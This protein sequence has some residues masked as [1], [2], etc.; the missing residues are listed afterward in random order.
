MF[1]VIDNAT[2]NVL[3]EYETFEAAEQRRIQIVGMNPMVAETIEVVDLDRLT[4]R[5][6][7]RHDA[8]LAQPA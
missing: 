3:S 8:S 4:A 6:S 5:A 1:L 2:N 7:D